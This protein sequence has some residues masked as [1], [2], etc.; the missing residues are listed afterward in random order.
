M[1]KIF[2]RVFWPALLSNIATASLRNPCNAEPPLFLPLRPF[3]SCQC[4]HHPPLSSCTN[5]VWSKRKTQ[6]KWA[7]RELIKIWNFFS[8][9]CLHHPGCTNA[10]W[11]KRKLS[12]NEL[13]ESWSKHGD[14]FHATA[15]LCPNEVWPSKKAQNTLADWNVELHYIFCQCQSLPMPPQPFAQMQ[16]VQLKKSSAEISSKKADQNMEPQ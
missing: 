8:C 12:Q 1:V 3:F 14:S 15:A 4:H 2:S 16:F 6:P 5:A 13:R 7:S 9:Q 10:V 11:P